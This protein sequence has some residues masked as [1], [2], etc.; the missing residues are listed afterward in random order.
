[1]KARAIL[2]SL[3]FASLGSWGCNSPTSGFISVVT[4]TPSVT[5]TPT[6]TFTFT[7][8]PTPTP[9]ATGPTVTPTPSATPTGPTATP[10]PSATPSP[11]ANVMPLAINFG[12]V[13][14]TNPQFNLPYTTV[15]ICT[16]GTSTCVTIP[17]VLV[18]T[19]STGLRIF[20]SL[21]TGVTLTP[22][23]NSGS[24]VG[25]CIAFADGSVMWGPERAAG[26]QMGSE[27]QVSVPIEVVNDTTFSPIP[28]SCS[29]QGT[30]LLDPSSALAGFN[31]IL[32]TSLFPNDDI[33]LYY[34]CPSST[35]T[36]ISSP[37]TSI[38]VPNPVV[39]LP[40]DN[41]GVVLQLP[42]IPAAGA[43]TATGT[44]LLGVGTQANN[45]LGGATVYTTDSLGNISTVYK[46]TTYPASFI[47]SGSQAFFF[48]DGSLPDC[49][50]GFFCPLNNAA[51]PLALSA[52]N[53]GANN[54]TG[55]VNF[56][57]VGKQFLDLTTNAA[58]DDI[59]ADAGFADFFDFGAPFFFNRTVF[60]AIQGQSA[61]GGTP[62]YY[63][64]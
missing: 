3:A 21:L 34:S 33:S 35:C 39:A 19:Q 47:D 4:P 26:L 6:P 55:T 22:V 40:F 48:V 53:T 15:N 28:S 29:A 32:G 54:A 51:N 44:M 61:P 38:L 50:G 23:M 27:P 13:P 1:M 8:T 62:P 25:T 63:A 30:P 58:F 2:F 18:D 10:T 5:R 49:G 52:Q 42:S 37:P 56:S 12:P 16:P 17:D 59:G 45:A 11:G 7:V 36:Q 41:N 20:A 64:Y 57:L 46:G 14:G 24:P 43:V 9:T 31:G 60:F